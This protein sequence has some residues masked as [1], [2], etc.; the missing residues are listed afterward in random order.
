[1]AKHTGLRVNKFRQLVFLLGISPREFSWAL[2]RPAGPFTLHNKESTTGHLFSGRFE[3]AS[4][5]DFY[6]IGC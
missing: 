5:A 1:M 4:A 3:T 2:A 6:A